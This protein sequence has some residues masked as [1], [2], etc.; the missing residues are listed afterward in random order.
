MITKSSIDG[1]C[2]ASLYDKKSLSFE[3]MYHHVSIFVHMEL[4]HDVFSY[5]A[6]IL[7]RLC[8]RDFKWGDTRG[9]LNFNDF[10]GDLTKFIDSKNIWVILKI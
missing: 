7:S 1:G 6:E 8:E 10:F 9:G 3:L 5:A 4:P 2:L